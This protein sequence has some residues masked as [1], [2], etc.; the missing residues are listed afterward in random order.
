MNNEEKKKLNNKL[1]LIDDNSNTYNNENKTKLYLV[2]PKINKITSQIENSP[3]NGNNNSTSQEKVINVSPPN[4][5]NFDEDNKRGLVIYNDSSSLK[6]NGESIIQNNFTAKHVK[7][8]NE[9][10]SRLEES[11]FDNSISFKSIKKSPYFFNDPKYNKILEIKQKYNLNY[12]AK[13]AQKNEIYGDIKYMS[14]QNNISE[15]DYEIL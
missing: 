15:E 9:K 8:P 14:D 11:L 6:R 1:I 7:Q 2:L 12:N 3:N 4:N 5:A 13:K 10:R